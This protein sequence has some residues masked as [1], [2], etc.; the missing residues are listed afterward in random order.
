MGDRCRWHSDPDVPGGR[1]LVPGCWNRVI[2]GNYAECHCETPRKT[3]DD[4]ISELRNRV[5]VLEKQLN[6]KERFV[7]TDVV[8]DEVTVVYDLTMSISSNDSFD[9]YLKKTEG[10]TDE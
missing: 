9:D 4:E 7:E 8:Q 1:F 3:L 2:Y 10:L 6:K 5:G